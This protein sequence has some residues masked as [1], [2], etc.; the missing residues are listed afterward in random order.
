VI[1][2]IINSMPA[3]VSRGLGG[4]RVALISALLIVAPVMQAHASPTLMAT[5]TFTDTQPSVGTF[6]YDLTLNNTG[7]TTIGTFWFSW[8]PGAGFMTAVPTNV[9]SPANWNAVLT[10]G[11][12]AIQWTTSSLLAPGASVTGFMFDSTLSP[13]QLEAAV[14][15]GPGA[16]DPTS[17]FFTYIAAPLA[18]P[19][20][21]GV[22]EP[23]AVAAVPEPST[24]AMLI[25]GFAGLGFMA[26]RRKST[27]ALMAA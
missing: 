3:I 18:D 15:S 19:G 24:W 22:A 16:G 5:A 14:G 17:T 6:A 7:T 1:G 12:K 25:L 11:S 20:F 9:Q 27:P 26:W 8:I 2:N 10:N 23:S 21:Q 13:T 4:K